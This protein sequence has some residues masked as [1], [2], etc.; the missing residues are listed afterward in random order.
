MYLDLDIDTPPWAL[1]LV[2][3]T[4]LT[5]LGLRWPLALL[6][7][8]LITLALRPELLV[9]G[10]TYG[11][12]WDLHHTLMILALVTS[13]CRFGLRW[14]I[15]WPIIALTVSAA[16]SLAFGV[17]HPNVEPSLMVESLVLLSLPFA[18]TL[19][20]PPPRARCVCT[21]L[22]MA[23][24]L[25]S[26]VIGFTLQKAGLHIVFAG[27]H[28]RLEGATG[29][30][31]VFGL[32]AFCGL[33]V[34]IHQIS[35]QKHPWAI[36]PSALNLALVVFSG[37]RSA[38]LAGGLLLLVYP[39]TS[40]PF[41]NQL[42]QRPLA[43]LTGVLLAAVASI[44]YLPKLYERLQLKM[45]R[46]WI[47]DVFYDEFLKSP[48]FGRGSGAGLVVGDHWPVEVERPSFTIPHN[49]YLHI[50]VNSGM[51][52]AL[53]CLIAIAYW[54]YRIIQSTSE[55]DRSFLIAL[56]P[57]LIVFAVTENIL[58]HVY[59]MAL[60]VYLGLLDRQKANPVMAQ[61][62]GAL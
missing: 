57:A 20:A 30:A 32:L 13:A 33:A 10:P 31:G 41:R 37:S 50:L 61:S 15:P 44:A 48:I 16:L 3:V 19:I 2:A 40:G 29:N 8:A 54:Y 21:P 4:L 5:G 53:L 9:G 55:V 6:V 36:L 23:L 52:G 45:D 28:D 11:W 12:R 47:W 58:I 17:L 51:I 39:F 25:L 35:R 22:I 14:S 42:R 7:L 18:F 62:V 34:S 1:G 60:F 27:L 59:S 38:M 26:V 43:I 56:A 49:E 46:L 24:P